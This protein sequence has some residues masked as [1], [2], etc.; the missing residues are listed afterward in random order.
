MAPATKREADLAPGVE[1]CKDDKGDYYYRLTAGG[2]SVVSRS[3]IILE[4]NLRLRK[5]RECGD[6]GD[7]CEAEACTECGGRK[8]KKK[9]KKTAEAA[10]PED[11][12][13]EDEGDDV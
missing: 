7:G 1:R 10:E 2:V 9:P 8:K 11:V 5:T 12:E 13:S 3:P 6:G 4:S